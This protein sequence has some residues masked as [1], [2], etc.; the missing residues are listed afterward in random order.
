MLWQRYN[1]NGSVVDR[2]MGIRLTTPVQ[3]R[4]I[5]QQSKQSLS[6]TPWLGESS[7]IM[8]VLYDRFRVRRRYATTLY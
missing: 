4:Y 3:N 2:Q 7:N 1:N 6:L 5:K 8:C